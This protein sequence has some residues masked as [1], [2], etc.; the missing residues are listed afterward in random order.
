MSLITALAAEAHAEPTPRA[1][2]PFVSLR[3]HRD[4][5]RALGLFSLERGALRWTDRGLG[6]LEALRAL[7]VDA[8][9]ALGFAPGQ[10]TPAPAPRVSPAWLLDEEVGDVDA[11]EV[12]ACAREARRA[13]DLAHRVGG[14]LGLSGLEV[15]VAGDPALAAS[16][17]ARVRAARV[18]SLEARAVD[19]LGRSWQVLRLTSTGDVLRGA[20]LGGAPRALALVLE[21][22]DGAL[23]PWLAPEQVRVLPIGR[24]SADGLVAALAAAGVPATIALNGPLGSRVGA[25]AAARV[26]Y[27]A[28]VGDD[29]AALGA[30]RVRAR[31]GAASARVTQA[32]LVAHLRDDREARRLTPRLPGESPS[33]ATEGRRVVTEQRVKKERLP[34]ASR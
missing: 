8:A 12:R 24:A 30:V 4:A 25:A 28:F 11:I 31:G 32:E 33:D 22:L 18:T 27:L 20:L 29:E 13:A 2:S 17:G 10:V 21:H 9:A 23:P 16:L 3:D 5:G 15:V 6:V 7:V 1:P 19:R 26:P 14:A 34:S